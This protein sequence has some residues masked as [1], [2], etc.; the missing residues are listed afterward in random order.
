MSVCQSWPASL[1]PTG[2]PFST[3]FDR[4]ITSG[5]PG[6]KYMFATFNS[7]VPK[8]SENAFKPCASSVCFGKLTT[9]CVPSAAS[10]AR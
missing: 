10:M 6:S 8:F 3:M 7:S 9:P 4:I 5:R 1:K 2:L